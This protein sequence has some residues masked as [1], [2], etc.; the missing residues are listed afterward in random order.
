ML[1]PCRRGRVHRGFTLIE[2]L[3]VIAIIAVLIALLLPAVQSAREAARRSQCT[4]NLKQIGL[5]IANYESAMG[6]FPI[7]TIQNQDANYAFT[8]QQNSFGFSLYALILGTMEQQQV[9]NA[10]NFLVPAGSHSFTPNFPSLD[11][12]A[13]NRTGLITRINSFV[14]PSDMDQTPLPVSTSTNGYS[15]TSYAGSVGTFDTF[16][17]YCGCPPS[18]GGLSCQGSEQIAGDGVFFGNVAV[19]LRDITDGTSNT[20]SVGETSRFMNDPD[21][22]FNSWS[23]ALWFGSSAANSA[24]PE[25]LASTVPAI[26][27][28][29]QLGDTTLF[30]GSLTPTNEVNAWL[31]L[32]CGYDARTWGQYG[33]HSFHPGGANFLFCDGSVRFLKQTIS[34]GNPN[35]TAPINIGVY[36]QLSTRKGG[37]VI[38]SDAY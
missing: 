8:C 34:M 6:T 26:N 24:R 7:G 18:P 10:I 37:E 3:V 33:F 20:I 5:A 16:H 31:F 28:P 32:Q 27:S 17:W 12:G 36:R 4:N 1:L 38:S 2:L 9:Y 13:I 14:C 21:I 30:T 22:E 11:V 15:Q 35:Y 25:A 23:R 19:P 29:F